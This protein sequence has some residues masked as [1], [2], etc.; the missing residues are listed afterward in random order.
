MSKYPQGFEEIKVN[1]RTGVSKIFIRGNPIAVSILTHVSI[2]DKTKTKC[3][4]LEEVSQE[5]WRAQ[6]ES[7]S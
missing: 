4:T 6:Y 2:K 7:T 1:L 3:Y 5:D